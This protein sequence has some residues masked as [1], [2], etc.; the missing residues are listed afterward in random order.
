MFF[1][2]KAIGVEV[3]GEAI[4]M[5]VVDGSRNSLSLAA[6][7]ATPIPHDLLKFG[8]KEQNVLNPSAFVGIIRDAYLRLLT[9]E[10]VISLSLPETTGRVMLVDIETRFKSK[11]EGKE[12]IRWKLK[13]NFS[14]NLSETH[15]DYQLL[16]EKDDGAMSLL[17]SIIAKPVIT[18]FEELFLQAGLEPKFIDFTG[19]NVYR[20]FSNRLSVT[21]NVTFF[22]F[23][24]GIFTMMVFYGEVLVFYR[25]KDLSPG[26]FEPNRLYRE[27][28]NSQLVFKDKFPGFSANEVFCFAAGE[29]AESFSG[30]VSDAIG[31]EPILLDVSRVIS[32]QSGVATD[33]RLLQSLAGALGAAVRDF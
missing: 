14:F 9:K 8:M 7:N 20:L 13:K 17:V 29:D 24:C 2:K 5:A 22:T 19:F 26:I 18:Q 25:S 15:L 30:V 31:A 3:S 4:K 27:I 32:S 10:T 12:I 23:H 16:E 1:S 6:Y 21:E 33:R 11:E 28:N